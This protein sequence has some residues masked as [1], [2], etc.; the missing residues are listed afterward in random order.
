VV[1]EFDKER[2]LFDQKIQFL[3]DSLKDKQEKE[4]EYL[5]QW[6]SQK[7]EYSSEIRLVQSKFENDMKNL[8]SQLD[9]ERERATELETALADLKASYDEK[10][11]L[12]AS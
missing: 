3:E 5:N 1:S 11:K 2:A 8:N 7:S 10:N 12:W 9:E 4:K 6:N